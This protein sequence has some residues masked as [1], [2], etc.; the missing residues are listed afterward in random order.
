[1]VICMIR[2]KQYGNEIINYLRSFSVVSPEQV[3]GQATSQQSPCTT[4]CDIPSSESS[5]P[6]GNPETP[7]PASVEL[8]LIF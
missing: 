3:T 5:F 7:E 6:G 1:M 8:P 2:I 4:K